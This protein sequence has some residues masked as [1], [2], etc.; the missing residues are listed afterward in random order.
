MNFYERKIINKKFNYLK[1]FP[2]LSDDI[3]KIKKEK[4]KLLPHQIFVTEYFKFIKNLRGLLVYHEIGSGKTL[5]SINWAINM[6]K[7]V[8]LITTK[9]LIENF[10]SELKKFNKKLKIQY[11]NIDNLDDPKNLNFKNKSIIFDEIHLFNY[12]LIYKKNKKIKKIWNK[13]YKEKKIKILMLSGTPLYLTPFEI[14]PIF[15]LLSGKE[16]FTKNGEE[17]VNNY[18]NDLTL[19]ATKT[20]EIIKKIYGYISFFNKIKENKEIT[21]E[22]IEHK[23]IYVKNNKIKK[24]AKKIKEDILKG[25]IFIYTTEEKKLKK[26]KK[27]LLKNKLNSIILT[28]DNSNFVLPLFNKSKKKKIIM[29]SHDIKHGITLKNIRTVHI[30]EPSDKYNEFE[31]ILGRVV[32]ICSHYDLDK[33]KRNV[34]YNIWILKGGFFK[35]SEEEKMLK[36]ALVYDSINDSF[37]DILK[38][39]A[40]D[41]DLFQNFKLQH[42][43]TAQ[44][45]EVFKAYTLRKYNAK[46]KYLYF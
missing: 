44:L 13:I 7:P 36:K 46:L 4:F 33:K 24:L 9:I 15:N 23:N 43:V 37:K 20:N 21:P 10:K 18:C 28:K 45:K 41:R 6:K 27:T 14:S 42:Y 12:E 22:I 29:G 39:A 8:I 40:V 34:S 17:F 32:R 31:Q 11:I 25:K 2:K 26:I 1:D 16:L 30:M 19:K 5:T 3:C 38:H 35:H